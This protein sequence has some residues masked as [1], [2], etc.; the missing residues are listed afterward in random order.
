MQEFLQKI[1]Q[2]FNNFFSKLNK[3]QKIIAIGIVAAIIISI[4]LIFTLGAKPQKVSVFS[5]PLEPQ[6]YGEITK[7]ITSYGIQFETK[8]DQYILVNDKQSATTIRMRLAQDNILPNQG[9]GFEIFDTQSW[10][11]TD[12]E[13]DV[14]KQRAIR[15]EIERHLKLLPGIDECSLQ[16]AFPEETLFSSQQKPVTASL[17][18]FPSYNSDILE[19]RKSVEGLVRIVT[20]GVPGLQEDYVVITDPNG[21]IVSDFSA[22]DIE[23][24]LQITKEQLRI[25]EQVRVQAE[26]RLRNRLA[27]MLGK[28]NFDVQL[29]VEMTF[30]KEK[31]EQNEIIPTVIKEDNPVTPYDDSEVVES[32]TI[33]KQEIEKKTTGPTFVPEGPPGTEPNTPPGYSEVTD[34]GVTHEEKQSTVNNEVSTKKT[35][36]ESTPYQVKRMTCSVWIDGKWNKVVDDNGNFVLDETKLGY[37]REY[38]PRSDDFMKSVKKVVESAIGYNAS[39]QDEVTVENIPFDREEEFAKEDAILK[40]Q[41]TIKKVLIAIV[42][43]VVVFFVLIFAYRL[44]SAEIQ[45]RRKLKEEELLR[46]QQE[47]REQALR[48]AEK[49]GVDVELSMEEKARLEMQENAIN[50][51]REHPEE[52]AKLIRTWLSEDQI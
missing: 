30:D 15:G 10:T 29:S 39:R 50:I 14:N 20:N 9:V 22:A 31:I 36:K 19:N 7:A 40:R 49:E 5:S 6:D 41:E 26:T 37:K 13:R 51:A 35:E 16:L 21:N 18:V 27:K 48:A 43:S 52:V 32:V 47:L 34:Q 23:N 28:D 33:S 12:F 25:Q 46:K 24:S 45:R 2:F 1:T 17:T 8:S 38:E 4:I 11:A 42:I 44:I 3:T